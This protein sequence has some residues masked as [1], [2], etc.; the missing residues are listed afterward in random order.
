MAKCRF[1]DNKAAITRCN[2]CGEEICNA[3]IEESKGK[4]YCY[5]CFKGLRSAR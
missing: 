2:W 1:H 5:H 4:K 3:C